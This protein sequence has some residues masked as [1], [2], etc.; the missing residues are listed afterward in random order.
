MIARRG[1][2]LLA[3][4]LMLLVLGGAALPSPRDAGAQSGQSG[5]AFWDL[6]GAQISGNV[7]NFS[8]DF[9]ISAGAWE[10][11]TISNYGDCFVGPNDPRAGTAH[12]GAVYWFAELTPQQPQD[13]SFTYIGNLMPGRGGNAAGQVTI[14]S[15][16]GPDAVTHIDVSISGSDLGF[17]QDNTLEVC[18]LGS[19]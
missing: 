8:G 11:V 6:G 10:S 13:S 19:S 3:G 5:V 9:A 16:Q 2:V 7:W 17:Y 12:A 15:T 18:L 4:L 14:S 1:T